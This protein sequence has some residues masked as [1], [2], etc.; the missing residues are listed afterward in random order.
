MENTRRRLLVL[1]LLW[2]GVLTQVPSPQQLI[3]GL[4][5]SGTAM[6]IADP[7]TETFGRGILLTA[8]AVAWTL[9]AW[10]AL[11]LALFVLS[12]AARVDPGRA[13]HGRAALSRLGRGAAVALSKIAPQLIRRLLWATVGAGV[14]VGAAACSATPSAEQSPAVAAPFTIAAAPPTV[15]PVDLAPA[16]APLPGSGSWNVDWPSTARAGTVE[17]FEMDWPST[18]LPHITDG[19]GGT[20]VATEKHPDTEAATDHSAPRRQQGGRH[21][22]AESATPTTGTSGPHSVLVQP[23]DSLWSIAADHLP[24]DADDAQIDAAWHTWYRTNRLLIGADP[25]LIQPGL[26]LRSP[27]STTVA[28]SAQRGD[29]P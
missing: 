10:A 25:D 24:N 5:G 11:V 19:A 22:S 18:D 12:L 21:R 20:A 15:R 26:R 2:V 13:G 4:F 6:S 27:A 8:G 29:A 14:L 28:D 23:G 16:A 7:A 3:D 1:G 17:S 9:T